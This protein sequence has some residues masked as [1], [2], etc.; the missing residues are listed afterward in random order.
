MPARQPSQKAARAALVAELRGRGKTWVEIAGVIQERYRVNARVA[1][2]MAR[3]W[4]Q[5]EVAALWNARWPDEPKTFKNI[6]CWELW[7]ATTGHAPSFETLAR[8]AELYECGVVDLLVDHP[9]YRHLDD[10]HQ[11]VADATVAGSTL[12]LQDTVAGS[13]TDALFG[14]LLSPN[15]ASRLMSPASPEWVGVDFDKMAQVLVMWM[16][17]AN[18]GRSRRDLLFQ[19]SSLFAVAAAAPVFDLVEDDGYRSR[20]GVD[21]SHRIDAATLDHA[22]A[23]LLRL[24]KQGDL[25]GPQVAV[26][27]TVAQ[28]EV[29]GR[30]VKA[31]PAKVRDRALALHAQLS[32]LA[33]WQL[34]NLGD[35]RTAEHYYDDARTTAH[36]ANAPELASYVLC[37]M[38]HLATWQ[39]KPRVGIDHALAAAAWA[40]RAGSDPARAYAAD[41]A[42]RA[43]VA[44][45]Q[46]AAAREALDDEHRAVMAITADAP[47]GSW[48]YFYDESFYWRTECEYALR[49]GNAEAAHDAISKSF[50]LADDTNVHNH[51]FRLLFRSEAFIGEG[52]IGEACRVIGD[53]A[54][55]AAV[56]STRRIGQRIDNLRG[57]LVR[58]EHTKPVRQL[59]EQLAAYSVASG[60][61]GLM[62]RQ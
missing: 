12:A 61:S 13:E 51:A 44:D 11:P 59:D 45:N 38:S 8:L 42:V 56:N 23:I 3:G 22:E 27:T 48:W 31:A 35:Y 43:L 5:G 39:G 2:R 34:F 30:I 53:V 37:T 19:L 4:S 28:R 6:S 1:L 54:G 17:T 24:R 58:W 16:Q 14:G 47:A 25:L 7:P 50:A 41:V 60:R 32:Q 29:V 20:A 36:E 9:D 62:K 55:L 21:Q 33:G 26:Q 57:G 52:E 15:L 10:A 40:E 46:R 18:P 49:F